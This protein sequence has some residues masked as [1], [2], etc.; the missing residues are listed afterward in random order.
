MAIPESDWLPL[1]VRTGRLKSVKTQ[2]YTDGFEIEDGGRMNLVGF[3]HVEDFEGDLL[4][5]TRYGVRDTGAATELLVAGPESGAVQLVLDN[6]NEAQ[7]A[8]IDWG[9]IRTIDLEQKPIIEFRIKI[10]VQLT[11]GSVAVWGLCGDHNAAVNTVAESIWFRNDFGS[12]AV[13]VEH[14]DAGGGHETSL[15]ATGFAF[16]AINTWAIFDIDLR[17]PANAKFYI[18]GAL[19][20]GGT[21][22][23]MNGVPTLQL[24]PV[25]RVG[26]EAVDQSLG[27][28]YC[29]Y[30]K[31]WQN[32]E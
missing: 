31:I 30:I 27:T 1:F 28:L 25:V 4:A 3:H 8:G 2:R 16:A 32:R 15:V 24:Q 20:A 21:T 6:T 29:D 9:N 12:L 17:E 23:N 13:T 5:K 10:G 26:N 7:L 11:I 14:D 18:N 19:V 22:F